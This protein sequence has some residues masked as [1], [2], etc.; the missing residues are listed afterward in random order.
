L[1]RETLVVLMTV[2]KCQILQIVLNFLTRWI[3]VIQK[4]LLV[5]VTVLNCQILQIGLNFLTR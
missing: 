1:I 2:L 5:L 3:L 4:T